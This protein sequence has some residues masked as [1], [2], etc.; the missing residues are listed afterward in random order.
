MED[1]RFLPFEIHK[2]LVESKLSMTNNRPREVC[3]EHD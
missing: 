1:Y 3:L 2:Q